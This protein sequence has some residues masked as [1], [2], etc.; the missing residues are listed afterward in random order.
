MYTKLTAEWREEIVKRRCVR[1]RS[2]G[3]IDGNPDERW[4]LSKKRVP[5]PMRKKHSVRANL[6]VTELTRVGTS[7]TLDLYADKEKI[8]Q[9]LIGRGSLYWYGRSRRKSKRISWSR[10]A[11]M[12][13]ELAYGD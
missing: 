13:N 6:Q 4:R 1:L 8:G 7:L 9:L 12:M 2:F 11:E 10:F 5:Q 3:H